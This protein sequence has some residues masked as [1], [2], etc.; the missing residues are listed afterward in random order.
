MVS[1]SSGSR[2]KKKHEGDRPGSFAKGTSIKNVR[3]VF[4]NSAQRS[5]LHLKYTPIELRE[6]VVQDR[7]GLL[8]GPAITAILDQA[9]Y[10]VEVENLTSE[11]YKNIKNDFDVH[12][13]A[14]PE[15]LEQAAKELL[16]QQW[17]KTTGDKLPDATELLAETPRMG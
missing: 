12:E 3:S 16:E 14:A 7:P 4:G 13:W 11:G 8:K 10:K 9:N 15:F 5:P 1:R 17:K 2:R 6:S